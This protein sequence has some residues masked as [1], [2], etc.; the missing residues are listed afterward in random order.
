MAE[1]APVL[2]VAEAITKGVEEARSV[3]EKGRV[4]VRVHALPRAELRIRAR[5]RIIRLN[6]G[7]IARLEKELLRTALEAKGAGIVFEDFARRVGDYKAAAAYLSFLWRNGFIVFEDKDA[8][9]NLFIAAN[10]LSQKTYEHK[11][12]KALKASFR[13]DT[14]RLAQ[15]P[16]D[17]I[18]CVQSNGRVL[19]R[20]I[21][22]NLPRSQA[23]AEVRALVEAAGYKPA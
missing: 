23:K 5:K 15:Q 3:F 10:A 22:A 14:E 21:V 13:L 12:A 4:V 8:A 2:D 6:E 1:Q 17:D 20:Y 7:K 18:L 9:L 11:I 19:C 16:F